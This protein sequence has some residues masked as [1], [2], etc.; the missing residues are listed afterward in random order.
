MGDKTIAFDATTGAIT[1][2]E[3]GGSSWATEA[4]VLLELEYQT[5][6]ISQFQAFQQAYSNLTKPPG[7]F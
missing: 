3:V 4:S 2:L 7:C 6:N 5:Y 1:Q